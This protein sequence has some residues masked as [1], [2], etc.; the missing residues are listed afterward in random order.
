MSFWIGVSRALFS[1]WGLYVR[2]RLGFFLHSDGACCTGR[3]FWRR[4]F[5][6]FLTGRFLPRYLPLSF[7]L[8]LSFSRLWGEI[9]WLQ[10][11]FA[12]NVHSALVC[13]WIVSFFLGLWRCRRGACE[14]AGERHW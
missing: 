8:S 10:V 7:F 11:V 9:R 4:L 6:S 12:S 14:G 13:V 2:L 5:H 3:G 1:F